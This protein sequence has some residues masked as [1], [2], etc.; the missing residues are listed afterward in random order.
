MGGTASAYCCKGDAK[1][2][3]AD[4][5]VINPNQSVQQVSARGKISRKNSSSNNL[6]P[7]KIN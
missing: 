5:K 6:P 3:E 7:E 2:Q 1:N 4:M